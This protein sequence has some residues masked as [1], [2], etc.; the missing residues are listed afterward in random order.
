ME[1]MTS[2]FGMNSIKT[3]GKRIPLSPCPLI[4]RVSRL[5]H[6]LNISCFA[7]ENPHVKYIIDCVE[8]SSSKACH[9]TNLGEILQNCKGVVQCSEVET[10][11]EQ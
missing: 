11:A 7:L 8:A 3:R 4:A 6:F 2:C 9:Q 10:W 1:V 5:Y